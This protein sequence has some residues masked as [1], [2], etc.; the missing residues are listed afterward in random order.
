MGWLTCSLGFFSVLFLSNCDK[1]LRVAAVQLTALLL[2]AETA[3][4]LPPETMMAPSFSLPFL[5]QEKMLLPFSAPSHG[6]T[7]RFSEPLLSGNSSRSAPIHKL[8][9]KNTNFQRHIQ[10]RW[11][12][13]GSLIIDEDLRDFQKRFRLIAPIEW[14]SKKTID[15]SVFVV[16]NRKVG[17][18]CTG[19]YR[20][21]EK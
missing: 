2:Y 16:I 21:L 12:Q 4:A 11:F 5:I 17:G 18:K 10:L 9:R 19:S 13:R 6:R 7:S 15:R 3:H 14:R 1:R 8:I 20:N